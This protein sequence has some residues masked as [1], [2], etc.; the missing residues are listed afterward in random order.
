[1][2]LMDANDE[3]RFALTRTG[4]TRHARRR[5][6]LHV[7]RRTLHVMVAVLAATAWTVAQTEPDAPLPADRPGPR[8][9]QNSMTAHAQLLDKAR[10][11]GIDVYFVGD[12]ITRRW[13]ALDY[14]ALLANWKQNFT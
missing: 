10:R 8:T 1:M 6:P 4:D 2:N 9:D 7:A 13:G 14:P 12:S 11:G 5:T 3:G